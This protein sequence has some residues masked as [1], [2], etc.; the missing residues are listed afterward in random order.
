MVWWR[1]F[2]FKKRNDE[3]SNVSGWNLDLISTRIT[4]RLRQ[5]AIVLSL[6][7]WKQRPTVIKCGTAG[8]T[9]K[10]LFAIVNDI[11]RIGKTQSLPEHSS[12]ESL[13]NDYAR[14]FKEKIEKIVNTFPGD[15]LPT[16][17]MQDTAGILGIQRRFLLRVSQVT[18]ITHQTNTVHKLIHFVQS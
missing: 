8:L 10:T 12:S 13:A 14:F 1:R 11:R 18:L 16:E 2:E 7:A 15:S 3:D 5:N 17:I 4:L 6:N 9:Q